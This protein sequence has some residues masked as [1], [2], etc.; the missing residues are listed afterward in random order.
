MLVKVTNRVSKEQSMPTVIMAGDFVFVPQLESGMF[1][2]DVTVQLIKCLE[3][4]TFV[5]TD[6]G[7]ELEDIVQMNV[8]FSSIAD[9]DKVQA[10]FPK[11]FK[12]ELFVRNVMISEFESPG[13][14][15]QIDAVAYKKSKNHEPQV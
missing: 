14:L 8:M 10:V 7:V 6:A 15:C 4:L 9:Y 12:N 5:L 1:L 2:S 13:C 11:F 3:N